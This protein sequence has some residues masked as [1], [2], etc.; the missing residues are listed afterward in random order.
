MS[1]DTYNG[2]RNYE[3]WNIA[4]WMDNEYTDYKYWQARAADHLTAEAM[5]ERQ[6]AYN[7]AD[8]MKETHEEYLQDAWELIEND[9]R[10]GCVPGWMKDIS[11]NSLA[12]VD[13]NSIAKYKIEDAMEAIDEYAKEL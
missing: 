1:D 9:L 10:N 6:A 4:L 13:W 11:T 12:L 5:N 2:W 8:E 3:T 7:L